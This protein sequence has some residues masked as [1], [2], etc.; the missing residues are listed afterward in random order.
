MRRAV[1][2]AVVLFAAGTFV[3]ALTRGSNPSIGDIDR[4]TPT[5]F[6]STLQSLRGKPIVVNFWATWCEPCKSELPRIVAAARKYAGRV[7]FLGVDVE[8]DPKTAASFVRRYE[9]TFRSLADPDGRIRRDQDLLGLP[10]T[11]FYSAAGEL[12]FLH[13]GEISAEELEEKIEDVLAL[14][15]GEGAER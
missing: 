2:A 6:D 15:S 5:I 13:N 4:G 11:Q 1:V 9:M 7:H 14:G 3:F 8:D 10:V 12:N